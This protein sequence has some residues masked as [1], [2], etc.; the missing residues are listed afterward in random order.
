MADER[1]TERT[2][3]VNHE[4]VVERGAGFLSE[5]DRVRVVDAASP[6]AATTPATP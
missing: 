6:E 2:D 4:R 3:G 1:V 5:G